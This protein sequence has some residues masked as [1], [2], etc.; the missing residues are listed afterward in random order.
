MFWRKRDTSQREIAAVS[1][2]NQALPGL[3]LQLNKKGQ[4]L[5]VSQELKSLLAISAPKL[6]SELSDFLAAPFFE[7]TLPV[8]QWPSQMSLVFLG[9]DKRTLYMQGTLF[10][11]APSWCIV[12]ID[13]TS[14]VERNANEQLRRKTLDFTILQASYIGSS[15]DERLQNLTE[16]W[17]EGLMLRLRLPWLYFLTQQPIQWQ[18]YA[19]ASLPETGS[20]VDIIDE[21]QDIL[22]NLHPKTRAPIRLIVGLNQTPIVLIPYA[23][24][25]G[26]HLW[27]VMSDVG[28]KGTIYG[29]DQSDWLAIVYLFGS[30]FYSAQR[31]KTMRRTAERNQYLQ[32][33]LA[34]GWWEYYPDQQMLYMDSSLADVLGF[35]LTADGRVSFETAM[36]AID[37]LD[38]MEYRHRLNRALY[39]GA[40]LSMVVRVCVNGKSSWY[41]MLGDLSAN[42]TEGKC[43]V[44][45]AMNID[46]LRQMENAV[47]DAQARLEGLI[48]NAPAIVYIL[49]YVNGAFT[50]DFCSASIEAMLGWTYEQ[51]STMPL[52]EII[53]PDDRE[54][55]YHGLRELLRVGSISR[56]YRVRDHNNGYHWVLD[57]SKLLRD[58]RGRPKEVV[59][60]SID[61]T[62][63]TESAE[64]V[65]ESE[66]RYRLLVEDA[67]A[68]IC[69]YLPDLS[70]VYSNRQLLTSLGLD[71]DTAADLKVNL[72]SF[73]SPENRQKLL[74]RYEQLTPENP[75]GSI[76]L[77]L[78]ISENVHA[79][80]MWAD[81]ATFDEQG[82]IIEI[83]SVGRDNTEVHNA[84]QQVYQSSKMATLG[85]MATGLAHEI[86]QPLTVMRM[87]LTNI[88]KRLSSVDTLD[89]QYLLKK[90]QR[91]ESQVMRVSK[92]VDHMRVFG[93]LSEIE[94]ALFDPIVSIEAAVALVREGMDQDVVQIGMD[95]MP[96]PQIKG[97]ND[98]F[99][100]VLINLLLN[101][102]YEALRSTAETG[103]RPW[104]HISTQVADGTVSITVEDSGKGIPEDLLDRIFEPFLTTKPV[105][106]GTGLG[107][108]VSYGIINLMGGK[109]TAKNGSHG[110]RFTIALPIAAE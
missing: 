61:V 106:K 43:L 84:R 7:M 30:P 2:E 59:G 17:L 63:A 25:D 24:Q 90:L 32:K 102:K 14:L 21:L 10:Y 87:A 86:S 64:L 71:P 62:E 49:N 78:N 1:P 34:S 97:H 79:W 26:V 40:K 98:R 37:P 99:E 109:L 100:Q 58:E 77:V 82:N 27:L 29:L 94:G 39:E 75:G 28:D 68:I 70:I 66:E 44:G 54:A 41:R 95:L 108:S 20:T 80:W 73:M 52:G 83:Q 81:R 67:P 74:T 38:E 50:L 15:F 23:E 16:E 5:E 9:Q 110:A 56:R 19:A 45:Y 48:Y 103:Q 105:G 93:R 76:E 85:E 47:S 91:V 3:S 35:D 72:G 69:R 31:N 89:P 57:E 55:Y 22:L 92:V 11:N 6:P 107:L 46:D 53:H 13:N 104:I 8:D 60:L 96:L 33:I 18:I 101:A 4:V 42:V 51:L 88:L 36:Q 12:L 65:R